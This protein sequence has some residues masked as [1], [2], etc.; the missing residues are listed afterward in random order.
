MASILTTR[1][2]SFGISFIR[3]IAVTVD[4][5]KLQELEELRT[6][7]REL[8]SQVEAEKTAG[9]SSPK[10]FYAE[11]YATTGFILGM[12][13]AAMSLLINVIGAPVAGKSPLELIRIY[14]TFPL[15]EKALQLASGVKDVYVIG[16]GVII[17]I[18]C[19]LYI[20][21]GMLLGVPFFVTLVWL[22]EGKSIF[23]RLLV[24]T[25]LAVALWAVNFYGILAWLQ[26]LLFGG[27]WITDPTYLP[28]WV[29]L[30]THLVFGWT[31]AL[32]Y[33]WAKF[34]ALQQPR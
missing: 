2:S 20:G 11:Y 33:P 27:N 4:A 16:D 6:R 13:G 19:C 10:S 32:L 5:H 9:Q 26:P 1:G 3:T 23:F 14:L 17:A 8:E 12:F 31:L 28:W 18:G 15:G 29:A 30:V 34:Q 25:I 24:A 7:V 22:T 21:I